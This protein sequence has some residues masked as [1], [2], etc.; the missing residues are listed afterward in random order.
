MAAIDLLREIAPASTLSEEVM[1]RGVSLPIR[2]LLAA[3]V[4]MI[5]ARFPGGITGDDA[6]ERG[7]DRARAVIAAG[8]GAPGDAEFEA[9]LK[10]LVPG[11]QIRVMN[12]VMRLSGFDL[13]GPFVPQNGAAGPPI[14]PAM[15][16]RRASKS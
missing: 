5:N 15:P 11:E 14:V 10:R 6:V 13:A 16:S 1:V 8:C 3:D 12:A 7:L 9:E 2:P 4:A